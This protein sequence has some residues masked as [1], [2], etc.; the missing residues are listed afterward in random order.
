M[1]SNDAGYFFNHSS[2][3]HYVYPKMVWLVLVSLAF[4][5]DTR[6]QRL[7]CLAPS[8]LSYHLMPRGRKTIWIFCT[9]CFCRWR[10]SSPG[11][12]RGK[13]V[14]YPLL[15]YLLN[16][17]TVEMIQ[18]QEY[19]FLSMNSSKARIFWDSWIHNFLS[20]IVWILT[21]AR[22]LRNH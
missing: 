20:F 3:I 16:E 19:F 4:S 10:E 21:A 12:L 11:R 9:V 17:M 15:L 22:R 14:S 13:R 5:G 8:L 7:S 1:F 2:H 18:N 6:S